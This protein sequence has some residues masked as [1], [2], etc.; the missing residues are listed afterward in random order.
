MPDLRRRIESLKE[1][2]N[3]HRLLNGTNF[4]EDRELLRL[5]I[6]RVPNK[7]GL[8]IDGLS[9]YLLE[10]AGGSLGRPQRHFGQS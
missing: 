4:D 10:H 1:K 3:Q 7:V 6:R 9:P 8:G 2:A 5:A